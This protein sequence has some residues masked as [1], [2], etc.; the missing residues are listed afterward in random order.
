MRSKLVSSIRPL[1]VD[2]SYEDW[3]EVLRLIY[4]SGAR[5]HAVGCQI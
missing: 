5:S 4:Y 2:G 3:V 1:Q